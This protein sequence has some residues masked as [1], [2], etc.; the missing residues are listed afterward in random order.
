ME[1]QS[2]TKFNTS[3][4]TYAHIQKDCVQ[5]CNFV[6]SVHSLWLGSLQ[7]RPTISTISYDAHDSTHDSNET[8]T[9]LEQT[10]HE[11]LQVLL[12]IDLSGSP[13]VFTGCSL[14]IKSDKTFP[15]IFKFTKDA[16]FCIPVSTIRP[17]SVTV[18]ARR[19]AEK[20]HL[21]HFIGNVHNKQ[22]EETSENI[23]IA[24]NSRGHIVGAVLDHVDHVDVDNA[25]ND[26]QAKKSQKIKWSFNT[27]EYK[28]DQM[29]N[30]STESK[31]DYDMQHFGKDVQILDKNFVPVPSLEISFV[32]KSMAQKH[33]TKLEGDRAQLLQNVRECR[34][35]TV[36]HELGVSEENA[37]ETIKHVDWN[38][39]Y[40]MAPDENLAQMIV[41]TR[42]IHHG[43][44][45]V[46]NLAI[47]CDLL[48]ETTQEIQT[49]FPEIQTEIQ[50]EIPEIQ[51]EI[52]PEIPEI[53]TEIQ[54]AIQP[55]IQPEIPEILQENVLQSVKELLLQ[56]KEITRR[57]AGRR[58][59][60]AS[61][62][63]V[64]TSFLVLSAIDDTLRHVCGI[65]QSN[66]SKL[67]ENSFSADHVSCHA[68]WLGQM[69]SNEHNSLSMKDKGYEEARC[70]LSLCDRVKKCTAASIVP[71][72]SIPLSNMTRDV[73]NN[74]H[75]QG[76]ATT[77]NFT[78]ASVPHLLYKHKQIINFDRHPLVLSVKQQIQPSVP[79]S[80]SQAQLE[81]TKLFAILVSAD[82]EHRIISSGIHDVIIAKFDLACKQLNTISK[83]QLDSL[84]SLYDESLHS[85][86]TCACGHST[87]KSPDISFITQAA[88]RTPT[89]GYNNQILCAWNVEHIQG[90]LTNFAI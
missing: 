78:I 7:I 3:G 9:L 20:L 41:L 89:T 72:S 85:L 60:L 23:L 34:L 79:A 43:L 68:Y 27:V 55:E 57:I 1:S 47:A 80:I 22:L 36:I 81:S 13:C 84:C 67:P 74:M 2:T 65:N 15:K 8:N 62:I 64:R 37:Q 25:D 63:Q 59:D 44:Q 61:V 46:S 87:D 33:I 76:L 45:R 82:V 50:P 16:N 11:P 52:Q 75:L 26:L 51:T 24:P 19:G 6:S 88:T 12:T 90:Q 83:Q 31:N 21:Q 71:E 49:E 66:Q 5:S 32:N 4:K 17:T 77:H 38:L 39:S 53:Q 56:R 86:I 28:C 29:H 48:A 10:M 18:Q 14:E 42:D 58:V 73:W 35:Q 54:P 69:Q 40:C 70:I 30:L